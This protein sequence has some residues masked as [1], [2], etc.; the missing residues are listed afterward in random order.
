MTVGRI[1][2]NSL[3]TEAY[4]QCFRGIFN[5]VSRYHPKYTV[6]K[7]LRGILMDW[8]D[9]QYNGLEQVVGEDV[10]KSIVKGCQV[11]THKQLGESQNLM[12]NL[13]LTHRST[14]CGQ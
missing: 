14:S 10:A 4:A 9:Q 7:C 1:H 8:S 2:L 12:T 13:T 6:G 5:T 11:I 3:N